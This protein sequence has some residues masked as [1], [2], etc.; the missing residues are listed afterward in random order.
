MF[1]GLRNFIAPPQVEQRETL[2]AG[3]NIAFTLKRSSKRNSIGLRIDDRGLTVSVPASA[4]EKWLH[5]VLQDKAEW[6]VEK[7]GNW[8]KPP[9]MRWAAGEGV[10]FL[11]QSLRLCVL[12][13]LS[14]TV[15]YE[16][17][18]RVGCDG[19][20]EKIER[21][22]TRWWQEQAKRLFAERVAHYAALLGVTPGVLRL[23][24]AK[25]QWGC[26]TA[27]G[28]IRLNRQLIKLPLPLIDYVVV[29]ELAHLKEMN[30]SPAFW[31]VV[32]SVCPNYANLRRELKRIAL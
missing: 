14:G 10:P 11:G 18:L 16:E 29:H 3:K 8:Q 24:S 32:S 5:K 20:A 23:S 31:K 22:V 13:G 30:H 25:K 6:V 7:L 17:E 28:T 26:C 21:Q 27:R 12:P 9:P 1:N 15:R 2:L 19:S 4:S